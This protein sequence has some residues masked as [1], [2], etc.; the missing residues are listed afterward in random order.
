MA[1]KTDSTIAD[2]KGYT[3]SL[4]DG[5]KE[6]FLTNFDV[7]AIREKLEEVEKGATDVAHIFGQGREQITGIKA[8]MAEAVTS[9]TLL[10]GGFNDIVN[11]QKD[12]SQTLGTNLIL[13]SQSYDKLF[14]TTQVTGRGAIELTKSFKDAGY[15]VYAIGDQMQKVMDVSRSIGVNGVTVSK[16]V[17]ENM[18]SMNQY[19]FQ[20]GVEG[21]A[22]MAAQA[23][24]LRIDMKDTL[25]IANRLF[26]P[27]QAIDMASAMQRLGVAQGD[28]LD[29]LKLMDLAQND[30]AELQNQIA[31]MSKS[32]TQLKA[33]GTGFE[34]MPGAKRQLIEIEKAMQL[35]TGQLSKMALAAGDLDLK[36]SRIKFSDGITD[37]STQKL[38]ANMAEMKDGQ[39]KVT[40]T[41]AEGKVQEKNVTELKPE[42]I[43]AL[44]E[45]SKPKSMEDIAKEQLTTSVK[46][47]KDI[48]SIKNRTGYGLAGTK[49][50]TMAENAGREMSGA[51]S[52]FASGKSISV[53]G[54]RENVGGGLDDFIKTLNE[55]K[56]M[57][58]FVN[59]ASGTANY[60]NT[61]YKEALV[62]GK[63]GFDDLSKSSNP[64]IQIMD[65]IVAKGANFIVDHEKLNND[66]KTTNGETKKVT[67]VKPMKDFV[68]FPGETVKP[69]EADTIFGMTRGKE[70][71]NPSTPSNSTPESTTSNI[72][73]EDVNVNLN[74]KID[75]PSNMDT[76][77]LMLAFNDQSVKGAL[78]NAFQNAL[79]N[80]NGSNGSNPNP[81]ES[82]KQMAKMA[83]V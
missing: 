8:A 32:F 74:I 58:A 59:A 24:N 29:P 47:Q 41:D 55:G 76:A 65:K 22:K 2:I 83:N 66:G 25:A 57:D 75:A 7:T 73:M 82:R 12:I 42:D 61:V 79:G 4:M 51:V 19:N 35:P 43:K 1:K 13:N 20:G 16:Q 68:K 33:D 80:A 56:P 26:D 10:G 50:V 34:I 54:V 46:M 37:E 15:S 38:I 69:L 53:K 78:I 60:M 72:K 45:A 6:A 44:E 21:M 31:K 77:Q 17:V 28:L 49:S 27:E 71:L 18:S 30:P 23:V 11:I 5:L 9:V 52:K 36:M 39:Y 64:L 3:Q 40:Y 62:K 70:L 14:A 48:E 81:I 67:E 63:E